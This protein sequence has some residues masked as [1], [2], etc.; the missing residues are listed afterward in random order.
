M[1]PDGGA[2]LQIF[3]AERLAA[4]GAGREGDP[5]LFGAV[6]KKRLQE[7]FLETRTVDFEAFAEWLPTP[8]THVLLDPEVKDRH[9]LAVAR[10][11]ADADPATRAASELLGARG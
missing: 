11:T 4:A 10:V 6:L 5:P 3:Q 9:G 7:F 1:T 8:G 2:L